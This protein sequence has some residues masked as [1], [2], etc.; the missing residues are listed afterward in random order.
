MMSTDATNPLESLPAFVRAIAQDVLPQSSPYTVPWTQFGDTSGA[1]VGGEVGGDQSLPTG[2]SEFINEN[3]ISPSSI[4]LT[5]SGDAQLLLGAAVGGNDSLSGFAGKVVAVGDAWAMLGGSQGGADVLS[6]N[7]SFVVLAG[8]ALVMIGAT[9]GGD[10]VVTGG[11]NIGG[12]ATAINDLFGDA[13]AM[14][15][16]GQGG[17]DRVTGGGTYPGSTNRLYGDAHT[18]TAGARGGDDTLVGGRGA[19]N[20]MWGDAAVIGH[21]VET[22]RDVFVITPRTGTNLIHDFEPGRDV[23]DLTAFAE[24]GIHS[25]AD[26]QPLLQVTEQGS[27]VEFSRSPGPLPPIVVNDFIVQGQYALTEGDFLFA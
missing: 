2:L 6:L 17:D 12:R 24:Q 25:L 16:P 27:R 15:G 10:D 3:S 26:L 13:Y 5:L 9:A 8:D 14:F 1:L 20:E 22:G 18:L 4:Y 7:G 21:G 19:E 11:G 23:I